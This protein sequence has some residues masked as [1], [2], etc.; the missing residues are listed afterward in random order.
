MAKFV[1]K[2]PKGGPMIAQ[3]ATV[4]F[5]FAQGYH[6]LDDWYLLGG[7]KWTRTIF[8]LKHPIVYSKRGLRNLYR[9]I[10][11][12][13]FGDPPM[14]LAREWKSREEGFKQWPKD[15]T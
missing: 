6:I 8:R 15:K 4:G 10:K 14:I 7:T 2:P 5:K 9:R 13:L 3:D 1:Y 12:V 11:R